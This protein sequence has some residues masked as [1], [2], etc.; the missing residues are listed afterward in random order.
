[1]RLAAFLS[2]LNNVAQ[3][4]SQ[5][6]AS[7]PAHEDKRP[8]LGIRQGDKG[9]LVTCYAGC[10]TAQIVDAMG[11]SLADLFREGGVPR[12]GGPPRRDDHTH[13]E[14]AKGHHDIKDPANHGGQPCIAASWIRGTPTWYRTRRPT[15]GGQLPASYLPR[16]TFCQS[17]PRELAS[18][19]P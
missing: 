1:M 17:N 6:Y 2:A 7:C 3:Q 15:W 18:L 19:R 9:I 12:G 14:D 8:S 10:S 16:S 5:Y 11:L 13:P 4:G